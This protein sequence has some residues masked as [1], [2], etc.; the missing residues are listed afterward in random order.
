[1]RSAGGEDVGMTVTLP[2][3]SRRGEAH[4]LR[5]LAAT[6]AAQLRRLA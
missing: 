3:E 5:L 2:R 1:M 6:T 4:V